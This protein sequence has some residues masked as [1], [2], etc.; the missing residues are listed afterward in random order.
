MTTPSL[1]LREPLL[2]AVAALALIQSPTQS[3]L[4]AALSTSRQTWE[5][6]K[7]ATYEFAVEARC[8][9]EGIARTPPVFR[10]TDGRAEVVGAEL[11][12]E[13]R[14]FYEYYNTVDKLFI[15]I[16]RSLSRGEYK[17]RIQYDPDLGYPTLADLDPRG[18]VAD[19]ELYLRVTQFRTI[20][21]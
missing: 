5:A 10:V 4:R 19:D 11:S 14:R 6:R 7:P 13:S 15:A 21:R 2:A 16:D 8:F 18:D 1:A 20:E 17:S 9:C 12:P 3:E